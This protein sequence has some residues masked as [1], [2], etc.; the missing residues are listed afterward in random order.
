MQLLQVMRRGKNKLLAANVY[1]TFCSYGLRG[2]QPHFQMRMASDDDAKRYM[3]EVTE[4][5]EAQAIRDS[6]TNFLEKYCNT[7]T[8]P[9]DDGA[10]KRSNI[11]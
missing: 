9:A 10:K 2:N 8:R 1:R 11:L 4:P 3:V 6:L 7:A 5:A